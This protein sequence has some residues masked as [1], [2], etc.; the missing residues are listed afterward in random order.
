VVTYK[1]ILGGAAI[2]TEFSS[3]M[4]GMPFEG[5]GIQTWDREN[6]E[7]QMTWTDNMGARTGIYTGQVDDG[8]MVLT[9]EDKYQGQTMMS[10]ITSYDLSEAK[11]QWS[12]EN[13]MD[14]G[15]TW[16]LTGRATYVRK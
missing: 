16:V 5:I 15:K 1:H 2:L 10:R 12:M 9:G 14:G 6:N 11:F 7:W 8:K 4:M 13:S 3:I